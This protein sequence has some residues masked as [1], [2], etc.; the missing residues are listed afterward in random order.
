MSNV[1]DS[2]LRR[3]VQRHLGRFILASLSL[4]AILIAG[5]RYDFVTRTP[6]LLGELITTVL[7]WA[8]ALYGLFWITWWFFWTT[9]EGGEQEIALYGVRWAPLTAILTR[10]GPYEWLRYPLAFGYLEFLWGLAFLVHSTTLA[11]QVVP[12]LTVGMILYLRL[13]ED[14]KRLRA[15]EQTFRL[16]RK[17]TPLLIPKIPS[18]AAITRGF[19]RRKRR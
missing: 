5:V 10:T 12:V 18:S 7:G 6:W 11:I 8:M 2:D 14:R 3:A 16:Y 1:S 4:A 17:K 9:L 13:V 15:H 19:K